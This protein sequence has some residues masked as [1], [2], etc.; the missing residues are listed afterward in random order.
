M[1][2]ISHDV[3]KYKD[4][5]NKVKAFIESCGVAADSWADWDMAPERVLRVRQQHEIPESVK[6][7]LQQAINYRLRVSTNFKVDDGNSH[8][9]DDDLKHQLFI[10]RLQRMQKLWFPRSKT[11]GDILDGHNDDSEREDDDVLDGEAE[12]V[13]FLSK[14]V[15]GTTK[16]VHKVSFSKLIHPH[17]VSRLRR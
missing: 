1:N 5:S 2:G 4:L 15:M 3:A 14:T 7:D 8:P 11:N 13:T 17:Y 6:Q 12:C 10:R 9:T 16:S